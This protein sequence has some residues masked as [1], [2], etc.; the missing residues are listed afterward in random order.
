MKITDKIKRLLEILK[1]ADDGLIGH[2]AADIFGLNW[3]KEGLSR[4]N[5]AHKVLDQ[6]AFTNQIQKGKG[7]Y[8]VK[9]YQGEYRE[10]DRAVTECIAKIILL[11]R[12]VTIHR[13]RP[14]PNGLRPDVVG[15][16]GMDG[17][18][19]AFV[20]EVCI[21]EADAYLDQKVTTWKHDNG[22]PLQN[23]F[24]IGIPQ[25]ALVVFGKDHPLMMDFNQFLQEVER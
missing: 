25:V 5:N 15:L 4:R 8:A 21:N 1:V 17:K 14:L 18:A 10:H 7:F 16:I 19:L 6:L 11:K 23:V 3:R 2:V 24:G 20:L 9:G 22:K 13:E 12:P